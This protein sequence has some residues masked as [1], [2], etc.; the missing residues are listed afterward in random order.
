VVLPLAFACQVLLIKDV[1]RYWTDPLST[2]IHKPKIR[3]DWFSVSFFLFAFFFFAP[4]PV[5]GFAEPATQAE[6]RQAAP[7]A[8]VSDILFTLRRCLSQQADVKR[9]L[10]HGLQQAVEANPDLAV[11]VLNFLIPHLSVSSTFFSSS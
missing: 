9:L 6:R 1:R 2:S 5:D 4:Q 11:H 8:L 3:K 10:Y 7:T